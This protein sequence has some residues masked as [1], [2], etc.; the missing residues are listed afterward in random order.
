[1][2]TMLRDVHRDVQRCRGPRRHKPTPSRRMRRQMVLTHGAHL[3]I[4]AHLA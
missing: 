1:M 2:L 3:Q 4:F